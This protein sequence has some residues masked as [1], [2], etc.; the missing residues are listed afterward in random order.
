MITSNQPIM[1][2]PGVPAPDEIMIDSH[3]V[4]PTNVFNGAK[5]REIDTGKKFRYNEETATWDE[6]PS[7]GGGGGSSTLSGLTDVDITNPS[8]GQTL[9]YNSTS[10]KW[11]NGAV[12]G[13]L[14][15]N[16]T[17]SDDVYTADKTVREILGAIESGSVIFRRISSES[18]G[19]R[20]YTYGELQYLEAYE[21]D[22]VTY[23]AFAFKPGT[24]NAPFIENRILLGTIDDYPTSDFDTDIS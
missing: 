14:L 9:V 11:E 3:D 4:K 17:E 10:G 15:V 24:S 16:I 21:E 19:Y 1:S 13:G 2:G 18:P 22:G 20:E 5:L 7:G 8:N 12:G 6:Q 23:Y